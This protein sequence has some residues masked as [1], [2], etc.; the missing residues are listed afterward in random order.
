ME[1][2]TTQASR[3][4]RKCLT[5]CLNAT[6]AIRGTIEAEMIYQFYD[7]RKGDLLSVEG[8]DLRFECPRADGGTYTVKITY[9]PKEKSS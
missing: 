4:L 1:S 8:T 7:P 6:D 3:E 9:S 5:N 2:K